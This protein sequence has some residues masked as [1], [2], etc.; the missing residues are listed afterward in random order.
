MKPSGRRRYAP[1]YVVER[2]CLN[3]SSARVVYSKLHLRVPR[4]YYSAP[5]SPT[6]PACFSSRRC[7]ASRLTNTS[8]APD[9][10]P[11]FAVATET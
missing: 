7:K 2:A 5:P 9:E 11:A 8:S 4:G 6:P 1:L 3:I 10:R